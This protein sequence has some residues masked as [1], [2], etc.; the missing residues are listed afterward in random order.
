MHAD[1]FGPLLLA[2]LGDYETSTDSADIEVTAVNQALQNHW[3]PGELR[4]L[5]AGRSLRT[6]AAA[7][8]VHHSTVHARLAKLPDLLG[9]DATSGVGQHRLAVA[10]ML[11]QL[12][13][14]APRTRPDVS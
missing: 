1:H 12:R 6:V 2:T 7:S 5:A 13:S 11:W 10:V 3:T 4:S 8:G 9:Y 14:W